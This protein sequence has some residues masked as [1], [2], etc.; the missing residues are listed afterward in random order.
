MLII[1]AINYESVF[2][3]FTGKNSNT[4]FYSS[5]KNT[6]PME[7]LKMSGNLINR[8]DILIFPFDNRNEAIAT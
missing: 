2:T 4:L 5:S 3:E 8:L 6:D 1:I 7:T